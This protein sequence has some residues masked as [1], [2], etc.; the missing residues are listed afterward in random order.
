[1][2][3]FTTEN[4][5]NTEKGTEKRNNNLFSVLSSVFSVFSVVNLSSHYFFL[6][7]SFLELF[8]HP[9]QP[10]LRWQSV[11]PEF[12]QPVLFLA[13]EIS[14]VG[15][16]PAGVWGIDQVAGV[17]GAHLEQDAHLEFTEGLPIEG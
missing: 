3:I 11:G 4:T 9:V 15:A 1:M 16:E 8:L 7:Q 13:G 5:E 6:L 10:L 12:L 14:A 2:Q 17:G